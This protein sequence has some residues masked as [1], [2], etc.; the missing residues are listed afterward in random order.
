M[1]PPISYFPLLANPQEKAIHACGLVCVLTSPLFPSYLSL[2]IY[3]MTVTLHFDYPENTLLSLLYYAY[4]VDPS[5][6]KSPLT[7]LPCPWTWALSYSRSII[8]FFHRPFLRRSPVE[9]C[10]M[11][12]PGTFLKE[13]RGP[14]RLH[15]LPLDRMQMWYLE[16]KEL[17]WPWGWSICRGQRINKIE[18]INN[19]V[20]ALPA[21]V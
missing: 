7:C 19:N 4:T 6:L 1:C 20:A 2:K 18:V 11:I 16:V 17:C 8:A 10:F 14:A 3:I 12:L 9:I 13:G 5:L 15:L 21:F